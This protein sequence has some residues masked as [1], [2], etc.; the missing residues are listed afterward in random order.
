MKYAREH[1]ACFTWLVP[2]P[3]L[4]RSMQPALSQDILNSKIL[5]QLSFIQ[6]HIVLNPGIIQ[7]LTSQTNLD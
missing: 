6:N 5:S 7:D 2:K 3:F 4:G 1:L